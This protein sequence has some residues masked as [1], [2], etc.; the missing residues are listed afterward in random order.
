MNGSPPTWARTGGP[1]LPP[2][3]RLELARRGTTFVREVAGPPGAPTVLLLH[4]W[5]ASAGINWFQVF[6][7]LGRDYRV[8]APDLRGHGRGLRT[9]RIF[10]LADC[11]D[12]CAATIERLGT[13]P[14]IAVGYSMGGPVAQLLWRRH[15]D[16][17]AGLVLCA[18]SAGFLPDARSRLAFQSWAVAAAAAARAAAFAPRL[19]PLPLGRA[20]PE[21]L[22]AW[23]AAEMRRHDW[24]MIVEAGHSIGTYHAGRWIGQVDVP[25]AVV[26]T[27]A[28]RAV[29]ADLQRAMA[30]AIPGADVVEVD[31]G[32]LACARPGFARPLVTAL[33]RVA[34]RA[35]LAHFPA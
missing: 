32:H 1:P 15:R 14:V 19:P 27:A 31:D 20:R 16:L 24:R 29:P 23:V 25:T 12:D 18:T 30:E 13:G 7:P 35:G 33:N 28:D 10:R 22:P 9:R 3:R 21:L 17:V 34:E 11:A 4:G 26:C 6:A 8:V 5:V 2:G